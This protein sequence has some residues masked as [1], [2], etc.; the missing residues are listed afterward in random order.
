MHCKR[1]HDAL[2]TSS[3]ACL[4]VILCSQVR[5]ADTAA[6]DKKEALGKTLYLGLLF[7]GWYMFNI[8]F[9]MC[10]PACH[11]THNSACHKAF[12]KQRLPRRRQGMRNG[13][14]S[15]ATIGMAGPIKPLMACAAVGAFRYNKKALKVF[16]Y[17]ITCTAI[18]VGLCLS[19]KNLCSSYRS[20]EWLVRARACR[21]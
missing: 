12:S 6:A 7:G 3:F 1:V 9:N 18:Q 19:C 4:N 11:R 20:F 2:H 17:P 16:P 10:V 14:D 21:C 13:H 8:W 5:P 15:L